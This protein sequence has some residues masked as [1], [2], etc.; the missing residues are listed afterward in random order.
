MSD[1]VRVRDCSCPGNPHEDGDEIYLRPTLDLEG[2]LAA[3]AA[4]LDA[5]RL[6]PMPAGIGDVDDK[7]IARNPAIGKIITDR[8]NFLR[9]KWFDLFLRHGAVGWNLLDE[10]GNAIPFDIEALLADYSMARMAAE[11]ANDR[12]SG[13]V[14]A[15]FQSPPPK[16]SRNGRTAGGTPRTSRPTRSPSRRSSPHGLVDGANLNA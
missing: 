6:F 16:H 9:P 11:E 14:L 1:G 4:L 2:G 13:A 7:L 15:P 5:A 8:T 3:E 12:Y 10:E